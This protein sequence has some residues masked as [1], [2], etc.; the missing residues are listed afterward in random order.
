[1]DNSSFMP[2]GIG[3]VVLVSMF[4]FGY[5]YNKMNKKK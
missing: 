5:F 2:L 1:M 4:A 3:L